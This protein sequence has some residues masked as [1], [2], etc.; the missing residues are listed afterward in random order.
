MFVQLMVLVFPLLVMK[1][2][3][4]HVEEVGQ[5]FLEEVSL[6]LNHSRVRRLQGGVGASPRLPPP[7]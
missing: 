5:A 4:G 6:Q 3:R 2:D 1:E 7:T